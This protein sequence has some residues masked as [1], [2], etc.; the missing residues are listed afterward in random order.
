[1]CEDSVHTQMSTVIHWFANWTRHQRDE[2]MTDLVHKAVPN[3]LMTIVDSMSSLGVSDCEQTTFAC[4][5]RLFGQWFSVWTD[6]QRNSFLERLS[7][8][9]TSFVDLL[10]YKIAA[11]SGQF[12]TLPFQLCNNDSGLFRSLSLHWISGV[13]WTFSCLLFI[14]GQSFRMTDHINIRQN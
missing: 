11:T 5:L 12:W 14:I 13:H 4:Q 7:D 8:V 1:M 2:F 3:K 10:N 9:D 6:D